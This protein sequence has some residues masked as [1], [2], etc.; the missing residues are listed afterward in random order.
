MDA[1]FRQA[2]FEMEKWRS[3][4]LKCTVGEKSYLSQG[5]CAYAALATPFCIFGL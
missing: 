2:H 1:T 5:I 3:K 4:G